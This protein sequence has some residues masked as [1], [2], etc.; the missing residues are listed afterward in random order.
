[1]LAD[2]KCRVLLGVKRSHIVQDQVWTKILTIFEK[3]ITKLDKFEQADFCGNLFDF[4][5]HFL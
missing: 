1:M 3:V 4:N 2:I 5:A